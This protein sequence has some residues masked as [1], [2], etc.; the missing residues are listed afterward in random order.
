MPSPMAMFSGLVPRWPAIA[1]FSSKFSGSLYCQTPAAAAVIA[2][3]TDGAGP[4]PLSLA[5]IRAAI[6]RPRCRSIASGPTKG[7][8]EGREVTSGVNL[9]NA[10]I[11]EYR[12]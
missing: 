1:C 10:D 12:A 3:R 2:D 8:V 5:P 6:G 4:K 11:A 7:I 9:E